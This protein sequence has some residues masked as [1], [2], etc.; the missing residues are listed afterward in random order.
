MQKT[1]N[2]KYLKMVALFMEIIFI[3]SPLAVFASGTAYDTDKNV[4]VSGNNIAVY[5]FPFVNIEPP[6]PAAPPAAGSFLYASYTAPVGT[7]LYDEF[8]ALTGWAAP[9]VTPATCS[10]TALDPSSVINT[11]TS[12]ALGFCNGIVKCNNAV[13]ITSVQDCRIA[14][15]CTAVNACEKAIADGYNNK[16][17]NALKI[18]TN[19][20]ITD[21]GLDKTRANN[22]LEACGG[23][24]ACINNVL[25]ILKADGGF[26]KSTTTDPDALLTFGDLSDAINDS[27]DAGQTPDININPMDTDILN[28]A[29]NAGSLINKQPSPSVAVNFSGSSFQ[30][31]STITATAIPGFFNETS[32]P[33]KLYFTWY[34]KREGCENKKNVINDVNLKAKC[35]LD[36]DNKITENDWKIAA[37]RIIV[38]KR[39]DQGGADYISAIN[40]NVAGYK[41]WPSPV[42]SDNEWKIN[43]GEE[44]NKDDAPNCYVREG[45]SGLDYELRKVEPIFDSCPDGY[46]RSCATTLTASTCG[47]LNP[48]YDQL[49]AN[50]AAAATPPA[51]YTISKLV[52]E[53]IGS[54]C[55]DTEISSDKNINESLQKCKVTDLKNYKTEID[56]RAD[57]QTAVCVKNTGNTIFPENASDSNPAKGVIFAPSLPITSS[58]NANICQYIFKPTPLNTTISSPV[59]EFLNEKNKIFSTIEGQLCVTT[60]NSMTDSVNGNSTLKPTCGFKRGANMCKHLFAKVPGEMTGDGKF[61]LAEKKFW[62][63]D[64]AKISTNGIQKDEEAVIGLGVDKF[65]WMF[66]PGD[67]IG[68]VVEGDSVLSTDHADSTNKRTW[69]FSKGICSDLDKL[70]KDENNVGFYVEGSGVT[71]KGFLTAEF[72]L[73][74]CLEENLITPDDDGTSGLKVELVATPENPINDP[75]GKG[76]ILNVSANASNLKDPNSLVYSWSVQKSRDGSDAPIDTT[77]WVDITTGMESTGALFT[78]AII[79]MDKKELAVYLNMDDDFIK[80]G[81]LDPSKYN[82][83]FYLKVRVKINGTAA[84][85]GQSAQGDVVVRVRQQQNEIRVYQVVAKSDGDLLM[86]NTNETELCSDQAG[87]STCY[88]TKNEILGLMVPNSNG[89]N[90]SG[91]TFSWTVNGNPIS[92]SASVSKTQ[93]TQVNGNALFFPILGNPGEAV[94]VVAK[95]IDTKTNEPI[96]V[97]RHFVIIEP[98]LQIIAADGNVWPKLLGYY[99]D[100]NGNRYPDYSTQVLEANTGKTI[101]LGAAFYPAWKNGQAGFDWSIDGQIISEYQNQ[102]QILFPLDKMPGESYNI[103]LSAHYLL[104][105]EDQ[106]NN[107]RKALYRNWGVAPE[108]AVE[109][110]QNANIQLDVI[111]GSGEV[112]AASKANFFGASLITHLPEQLMFLLKISLTSVLLLMVTGLLFAFIPETLFKKE[113]E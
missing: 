83:V 80:K 48:S 50:I 91:S 101:M 19:E 107:I 27:R 49:A 113:S 39:F 77:S 7:P 78:D 97:S 34:L 38:G 110:N 61:T 6:A 84:D 72:D 40:E 68:V 8:G 93:C 74:N 35:D 30:A 73:D 33:K 96:E 21:N 58:D 70:N 52:T 76:D 13:D 103:G 10:D 95:A 47:V 67:Q 99:K 28:G 11:G 87:K 17:I 105:N 79:G 16:I 26:T 3:A 57:D 106:L 12:P 5:H 41:A 55:V 15:N 89:A 111:A 56:C 60:K 36:D 14:N 25:S 90:L 63:A 109:E 94:E 82:G 54:I 24:L 65:S 2:K 86:N 64:P 62:G 98:Q 1:K 18:V 9:T 112:V 100:L 42:V 20:K 53:N 46:H 66:S 37:T 92:C 69:A 108:E 4:V 32:D 29:D 59:P 44:E 102:N 22:A 31:G 71:K 81:L 43:S 104:G 45:E 88:V 85:G 51:A 75:N 23:D